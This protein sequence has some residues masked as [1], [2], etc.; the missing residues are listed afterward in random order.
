MNIRTFSHHCKL[1]DWSDEEIAPVVDLLRNLE[2]RIDSGCSSKLRDCILNIFQSRG[3]SSK[4]KLSHSTEITITAIKDKYGLCFQTGNMSR[5][6]ADLLK[7]QYLFQKGT[8]YKALYLLPSK[9]N[10]KIIGG[11]VA[12]YERMTKELQLF[13]DIITIPIFI[14]GID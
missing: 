12:N 2:F 14:I 3:W 1:E 11:N 4:V 8:I 13:G 10:A 6:Y 5:F 7:L 9:H